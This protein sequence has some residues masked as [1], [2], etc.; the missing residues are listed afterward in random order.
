[1]DDVTRSLNEGLSMESEAQSSVLS[2]SQI[3]DEIVEIGGM[4]SP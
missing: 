3:D 2:R 1:M 4:F